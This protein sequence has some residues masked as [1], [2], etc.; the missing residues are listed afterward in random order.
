VLDFTVMSVSRDTLG[1]ERFSDEVDI[2][3]VKVVVVLT[4]QKEQ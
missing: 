2:V 1:L 3:T 4:S